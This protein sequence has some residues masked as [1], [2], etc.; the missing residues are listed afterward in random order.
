MYKTFVLLVFLPLLIFGQ[1]TI[2][3]VGN[4][5]QYI[6]GLSLGNGRNDDTS[7]VYGLACGAYTIGEFTYSGSGWDYSDTIAIPLYGERMALGYGRNDQVNRIY[8]GGF[9]SSPGSGMEFTYTGGD[10]QYADMGACGQQLIEVMIGP[11]R[12]DDTNRVYFSCG[13]TPPQIAAREYSYRG[14][15]WVIENIGT[16]HGGFGAE[17]GQGRNDGVNRFYKSQSTNANEYTW[18]SGIW[19][20]TLIG[21]SPSQIM[22]IAV[23][24]GRNDDTNRVYILARYTGLLE[25]TYENNSWVNT[26]SITIGPH[27]FNLVMGDGRND[28]RNRFYIANYTPPD[29]Y[30]VYY[31]NGNWVVNNIGSPGG[32]LLYGI[33]LGSGRSGSSKKFVY[34]GSRDG[35]IYEF[36][37]QTSVAEEQNKNLPG[38]PVKIAPNPMFGTCRIIFTQPV[39]QNIDVNI[40]DA[41]GALVR[42]LFEGRLA[43]GKGSIAWDGKNDAGQEVNN[44][45][46]FVRILG[47]ETNLQNTIK[48]VVVK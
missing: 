2:T 42:N 26:A 10:W 29:V 27:N 28:G 12:N 46:Y 43:D 1:W 34:V 45:I 8:V 15:S 14:S 5:G 7:R 25:Y 32:S 18:T 40:Y 35:G 20:P 39:G 17:I 9:H 4:P 36:E 47:E 13:S 6:L 11:G 23:G 31:E 16:G 44:G 24:P 19:V 37:Y 33:A 48:I 41:K 30:E 3:N 38:I 22:K 21:T